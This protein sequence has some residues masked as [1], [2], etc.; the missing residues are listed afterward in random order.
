MAE[1]ALDRLAHWPL[2]GDIPRY[3]PVDY[4]DALV[5]GHAHPGIHGGR[6]HVHGSPGDADQLAPAFS[7]RAVPTARPRLAGHDF[8]RPVSAPHPGPHRGP[9]LADAAAGH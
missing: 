4:R 6:S 5:G 9:P 8:L 7:S 3:L 1:A 2:R